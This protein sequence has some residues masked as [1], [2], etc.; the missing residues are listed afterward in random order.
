MPIDF[1]SFV[2]QPRPLQNWDIGQGFRDLAEARA[3]RST[4][5][6]SQAQRRDTNSYNAAT[7]ARDRSNN[8]FTT[9]D[10][11]Y[12]QRVT[13]AEAMHRAREANDQA[14][15][16]ALG[17]MLQK[18]GG[19]YTA[20]RGPN[21]INDVKYDFDPGQAPTRA[22]WDVQ[23]MRQQIYGGAPGL[24]RNPMDP[25]ALPGLSATK[26]DLPQ[27]NPNAPP[28]AAWLP[29]GI[30]E[31][32]PQAAGPEGPPPGAAVE[33]V[34]PP[35]SS[36]SP[37]PAAAQAPQFTGP[38]PM[39]P[40]AFS[41]YRSQ[42]DVAARNR[43]QIQP[44]L[45]SM[46]NAAPPTGIN[47]TALNKGTMDAGMSP[48]TS[49]ATYND[50]LGQL[51]KLENGRQAAMAAQGRIEQSRSNAD[52]AREDKVRKEAQTN[53]YRIIQ[54]DDL[55]KVKLKL[56][57]AKDAA[58]MV[59]AA[60]RNPN[61]ANAV[62]T[63]LYNMNED[64]LITNQDFSRT[65]DGM[66]S[67]AGAIV[68]KTLN[69]LIPSRS[70]LYPLMARDIKQTI[71]YAVQNQERTMRTAADHLYEMYKSARTEEE[72]RVY[73]DAFRSFFDRPYWPKEVS[74]PWETGSTGQ[75]QPQQSPPPA[76]NSLGT[77]PVSPTLGTPA[78]Q[79][80]P[81]ATPR[82]RPK[83]KPEPAPGTKAKKLSDKDI[84]EMSPVDT[85]N[86]LIQLRKERE[87]SE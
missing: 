68:S 87:G 11:K 73:E 84:E 38:N 57:A 22:P 1:S 39:N 82:T 64:G 66:Q 18:L 16:E 32:Q 65:S 17:P 26:L 6:E 78:Q 21:G 43:G 24:A 5:E 8:E 55:K 86:M 2:F 4:L 36:S 60:T 74:E 47:I 37:Q 54:N 31:S 58:A 23:G 83:A 7:F 9:A 42:M 70:A 30:A 85:L 59:D 25:Q 29:P 69:V 44:I 75:Q 12:K 62:I 81:G 67:V 49:L 15:V 35:A 56:N 71:A 20:L 77:A 52:M 51:I 80:K 76:G 63:K 41:Q 27:A 19:T 53:A 61:L 3:R 48:A 33:G 50:Q 34:T 13:L 10:E 28:G 45:E 14:T 46:Q 79:P 72:R 40:P